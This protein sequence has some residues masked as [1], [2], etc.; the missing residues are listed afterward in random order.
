MSQARSTDEWIDHLWQYWLPQ[1]IVKANQLAP[2]DPSLKK[3]IIDVL[4]ERHRDQ[5]LSLREHRISWE[6]MR[7][8][9]RKYTNPF[10]MEDERDE[11]VRNA[12]ELDQGRQRK[13]LEPY[14]TE[15]LRSHLKQSVVRPRTG[16]D[17]PG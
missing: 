10:L 17:N 9:K 5:I 6:D 7:R 4:R 16:K 2:G 8:S 15:Y 1:A 13:E 11:F 12:W 14:V 3:T